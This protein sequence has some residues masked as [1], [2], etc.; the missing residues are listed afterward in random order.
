MYEARD[1]SVLLTRSYDTTHSYV[2][3]DSFI[4]VTWLI[5]MCDMT[6][7]YV[8]HDSR[9]CEV[10]DSWVLLTCSYAQF[11][12]FIRV[13]RLIHIW[14]VTHSYVWNDSSSVNFFYNIFLLFP[15]EARDCVAV[16]CR[17]LY[18]YVAVWCRVLFCVCC[19]VLQSSFWQSKARDLTHMNE[20]CHTYEWVTSHIW[21]SHV[22]H[23]NE[24]CHT[25]K[26]VMSH[27][28]QWVMS[29][30]WMSHVTCKNESC[31]MYAQVIHEVWQRCM[32]LWCLMNESCHTYE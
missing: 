15:G 23:M 11:D 1:L 19:T 28:H 30:T 7:S 3:H 22:P 27:T 20:S 31:H 32:Y 24:S 6:H 13:T 5:H 2:W 10:R 25:Y 29:H 14:D 18:F 26:W 16:C 12:P 17:V 4:R 8:W 21:M 9:W